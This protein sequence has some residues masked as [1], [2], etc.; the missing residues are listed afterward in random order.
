MIESSFTF[1]DS[2]RGTI[3]AT[4]WAGLVRATIFFRDGCRA[5]LNVPNPGEAKPLPWTTGSGRSATKRAYTSPSKPGEPPRTRTGH[6]A[7]SVDMELDEQGMRS[8]VGIPENAKY[9]YWLEVGTKAVT[10]TAK[11]GKALLFYSPVLGKWI[12]RKRIHRG[13][14]APRPWMSATLTKLWSALEVLVTATD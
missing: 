9:G 7:G 6:L 2:A 1:D 12:F 10:I 3:M 4:A 14:M 11:A 13:P 5:T 8:R